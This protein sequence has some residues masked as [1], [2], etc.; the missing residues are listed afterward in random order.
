VNTEE[1]ADEER[2]LRRIPPWHAPQENQNP[3]GGGKPILRPPSSAFALDRGETGLSFHIESSLRAAGE[4]LTYGCPDGEPG[5]AVTRITAATVRTFGL[6][7]E[8]DGLPHHVLVLGLA[9]LKGGALR[10]MQRD[11]AKNSE[12]VALP[13]AA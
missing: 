8:R 3:P 10:R 1:I 6:R 7:I 5:W 13:R 2:L 9:E 4:Q 11:L 12:Y